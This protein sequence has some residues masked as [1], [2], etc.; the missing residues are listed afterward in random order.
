M[1]S[2]SL[3]LVA[4]AAAFLLAPWARFPWTDVLWLA[5]AGAA[6]VVFV[7]DPRPFPQVVG[8]ALG[9][10][11][12][13]LSDRSGQAEGLAKAALTGFLLGAAGLSLQ[14]IQIGAVTLGPPALMAA[15][16]VLALAA[17][18]ILSR[19]RGGAMAALTGALAV[20]AFD[21]VPGEA[22]LNE[23]LSDAALGQAA[24]TESALPPA[25]V[26]TQATCIRRRSRPSWRPGLLHPVT[27]PVARD[28]RIAALRA[29]FEDLKCRD[30]E[31]QALRA[32]A[33]AETEAEVQRLKEAITAAGAD[34]PIL[35]WKSG[36]LRILAQG[37][38]TSPVGAL[39]AGLPAGTTPEIALAVVQGQTTLYAEPRTEAVAVIRILDTVT[40]MLR[41]A[42]VGAFTLVWSPRDQFGFVLRQFREVY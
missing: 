1:S 4:L 18:V 9:G 35:T 28:A 37:L 36:N 10:L 26:V 42:E 27:E 8:W 22:S 2:L 7:S 16:G 5:C 25:M 38:G 13:C 34:L 20:G 19:W 31:L 33:S 32:T 30:A 21:A 12:V 39:P 29:N 3:G 15:T 11:L 23:H 24:G 6:L 41:V 17:G 14:T 40:T